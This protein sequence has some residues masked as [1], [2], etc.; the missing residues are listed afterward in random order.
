MKKVLLIALFLILGA[1][2]ILA[3]QDNSSE[4]ANNSSNKNYSAEKNQTNMGIG[5]ELSEQIRE[6][7]EEIKT[8]DY[9]G[10]LGQLLKVKELVQN[11][12]ELRVNEVPAETDLNITAET[13]A[14][15]KTKFTT[16]LKNGKDLE[17]KIMP[18]T[19]SEKALERLKLKVCSTD[20]NCTIQLKNIGSGETE[21]VQYEVQIERH[22]K[23]LGIFQKKMQ[24]SADVDAETGDVKVNKPWWAFIATEPTE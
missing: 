22:S 11:L 18:N 8:G 20:N 21:R 5:Q 3:V 9:N 10:S 6:R 23:I 17:I 1:G 7:K 24:V 16:K 4:K 12:K 15:G 19:A 14:E 2:L 13:D